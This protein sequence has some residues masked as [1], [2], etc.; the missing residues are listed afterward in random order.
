MPSE[1]GKFLAYASCK[2][3]KNCVLESTMSVTRQPFAKA[4]RH[5]TYR[6]NQLP[7]E[8]HCR[9][10]QKGTEMRGNEESS[11]TAGFH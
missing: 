1:I 9:L 6:S 5:M 8:K 11:P 10:V 4:T 7:R 2:K 3:M